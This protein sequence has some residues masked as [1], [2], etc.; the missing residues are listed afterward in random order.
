MATGTAFDLTV[1]G[2]F[3]PLERQ[4]QDVFRRTQA[5]FQKPIG[6]NFAK[7]LGTISGNADEFSKSMAAANARVVAFSASAGLVFGMA[8]AMNA[9]VTATIE[10]DK[11]FTDLN[12]LL[13]FSD[14]SL[15]D[16]GVDLVKVANDTG[17]SLLEIA[18]GA[19]ELARQGLGAEQTLIR[20]RDAGILARQ[21]GLTLDE[22]ITSLTATLNSFSR[23]A[24]ESTEVVN[25]FANVDAAFAVS[26]ADLA[27]A[28]KRVG[29][30]AATAGVEIDELIALV[31]SLQQTT[32]RGGSVIGNGLK[33]ILTR[34][35]R[36]QVLGQL[37]QAGVIIEDLEGKTLPTIQVLRNFAKT[38]QE[39]GDA[40]QSF[41]AEAVGSV[42]QINFLKALVSDLSKEYSIFD[43]A[44]NTSTTSTNEA[45]ERND[46]L[47]ESLAAS[48]NRVKNLATEIGSN[49][50]N[51]TVAPIL[52]DLIG[53][54]EISAD[55]FAPLEKEA[56]KSSRNVGDVLF[57]GLSKGIIEF[58]T[59]P[60]LVL[61]GAVI[62][63]LAIKF[64]QFTTEAVADFL[65]FNIA[66]NKNIEL[67]AKLNN[68]LQT[69]PQ[70]R[71]Q[72]LSTA[73]NQVEVEEQLLL[74][75]RQRLA[76]EEKINTFTRRAA[77]N[78][79]GL[80]QLDVTSTGALSLPKRRASGGLIPQAPQGLIPSNIDRGSALSEI[81]GAYEGG[82]KP[83]NLKK[84]FIKGVGDVVYNSAEQVLDFGFDQPAIVPPKNSKAGRN[85]QKNFLKVHGFDPF[86]DITPPRAS[87]RIAA[88]G[89]IPVSIKVPSAPKVRPDYEL[90]NLMVQEL[91][92][93]TSYSEEG[94]KN[95]SVKL[96]KGKKPKDK[97][98]I[99]FDDKNQ[100]ATLYN[101]FPEAA[102]ELEGLDE[103]VKNN[104]RKAQRSIVKRAAKTV[105]RNLTRMGYS[106]IETKEKGRDNISR[107][108]IID[109]SSNNTASDGFIPSKIAPA[110]FLPRVKQPSF[111]K[112]GRGSLSE[113]FDVGNGL[114]G[115]R[116]NPSSGIRNFAFELF[117]E[118]TGQ[119]RL[120]I[121]DFLKTRHGSEFTEANLFQQFIKG[122]TDL[123]AVSDLRNAAALENY[124]NPLVGSPIFNVAKPIRAATLPP[125]FTKEVFDKLGTDKVIFQKL[126]KG[127]IGSPQ[128]SDLVDSQSN[129]FLKQIKSGIIPFKSNKL[130]SISA[131]SDIK[132]ANIID[133][134][135]IDLLLANKGF[136]P[137]FNGRRY[138]PEDFR[139]MFANFKQ[140]NGSEY[141]FDK[142]IDK[143]HF[144]LLE[145]YFIPGLKEGRQLPQFT[146]FGAE[147][148]VFDVSENSVLK[149]PK[150]ERDIPFVERVQ[151]GNSANNIFKMAGAPFFSP[152]QRAIKLGNQKGVLQ[153][154]VEGPTLDNF[155]NEL[156]R[157]Q[158]ESPFEFD[159]AL[160]LFKPSI[161]EARK[162][163]KYPIYFDTGSLRNF[164]VPNNKVDGLKDLL[165]GAGENLKAKDIFELL[166][167]SKDRNLLATIDLS[168]GFVPNFGIP[169]S[170]AEAIQKLLATREKGSFFGV[171]FVKRTDGTLRKMNARLGVQK[172]KTG[173]GA[174]YNF[175]EKELIP[176]TDMQLLQKFAKSGS[177][178]E[179]AVQKAR[180]S[181][182]YEGI[183]KITI[184]GQE[185]DVFNRG[186]IPNS[187]KLAE[188]A[189]NKGFDNL[190]Y[191]SYFPLDDKKNPIREIRRPSKFPTFTNGIEPDLEGIAGFFAFD[192]NIA[193]RFQ[194]SNE[195][196]LSPFFAQS[197]K[198]Y[199]ID[200]KGDFAGNIQ[201]GDS[202]T[203]FRDIVRSKKYDSIIIK[204]TKDE[205]D[206]FVSL[207]SK[208]TKLALPET[209]D[210]LG[211]IVPL[212]KRFDSSIND[213]N[214]NRGLVPNFGLVREKLLETRLGK[215]TSRFLGGENTIFNL[216]NFNRASEGMIP[217]FVNNPFQDPFGISGRQFP[218]N[219]LGIKDIFKDPK[220]FFKQLPFRATAGIGGS[221]LG[222]GLRFSK[223]QKV[224][225]FGES[226]TNASRFILGRGGERTIKFTKEQ[227]NELFPKSGSKSDVYET[228]LS[229]ER[230]RLENIS[231]FEALKEDANLRSIGKTGFGHV[232]VSPE[233]P[234]FNA[235]GDFQGKTVNNKLIGRDVFDFDN[236]LTIGLRSELSQIFEKNLFSN[237]PIVNKLFKKF[238]NLGKAK[239]GPLGIN[240]IPYSN[241]GKGAKTQ[242]RISGRD[243]DFAD[244]GTPF[245]TKLQELNSGFVPNFNARRLGSG[246]FADFYDTGKF[247]K[248]G[249]PIGTK[250]FA[251]FVSDYNIKEEFTS[252]KTIDILNQRKELPSIF[253]APRVFGNQ[254]SAITNRAIDKEIISGKT[255]KD[256]F[257]EFR[258]FEIDDYFR[259]AEG[260]QRFTDKKFIQSPTSSFI[261]PDDTNLSNVILNDNFAEKIRGLVA[262]KNDFSKLLKSKDKED[263]FSLLDSFGRSGAKAS[264]ID[265]GEFIFTDKSRIPNFNAM[266]GYGA[267][268]IPN[269]APRFDFLRTKGQIPSGSSILKL[270]DDNPRIRDLSYLQGQKLPTQ[271]IKDFDIES[272]LGNISIKDS[273]I[274]GAKALRKPIP[275][276]LVDSKG[277][278]KFLPKKIRGR[279]D[280]IFSGLAFY[281]DRP[282]LI[283]LQGIAEDAFALQNSRNPFPKVFAEKLEDTILHEA[284]HFFD[285]NSPFGKGE[286]LS[287]LDKFREGLVKDIIRFGASI[288]EITGISVD[289]NAIKESFAELFRLGAQKKPLTVRTKGGINELDSA[290][291]F[292]DFFDAIFRGQKKQIPLKDLESFSSVSLF[293]GF[294]KGFVPNFANYS[295]GANALQEAVKREQD[296]GL[297][298]NQIKIGRDDRLKSIENPQG[299]GVFNTRDEPRG[300]RQGIERVAGMG[301]N[302]KRAGLLNTYATGFIPSFQDEEFEFEGAQ[303]RRVRNIR[304]RA[305]RAGADPNEAVQN[306]IRQ[307]LEKTKQLIRERNIKEGQ[308]GQVLQSQVEEFGLAKTSATKLSR[309]YLGTSNRLKQLNEIDIQKTLSE[310]DKTIERA[311]KARQKFETIAQ[312]PIKSEPSFTS[313]LITTGGKLPS[314]RPSPIPTLVD[315]SGRELEPSGAGLRTQ[316][317]IIEDDERRR[318]IQST[319][320][321]LFISE[322]A[323]ESLK[324]T[325]PGSDS[326]DKFINSFNKGIDARNK[327][328]TES[329]KEVF[330]TEGSIRKVITDDEGFR[331]PDENIRVRLSRQALG[332]PEAPELQKRL[333]EFEKIGPENVTSSQIR[334]VSRFREFDKGFT[335]FSRKIQSSLEKD[336]K[337]VE[338]SLF[339]FGKGF[340]QA[341]ERLKRQ[342]PEALSNALR[343]QRQNPKLLQGALVTSFAAPLVGG[344]LSEA[345]GD[346][347]TAQRGSQAA[348]GGLTNA[349]SFTAL[350]ASFGAS[351]IL[352]AGIGLGFLAIEIPKI[353]K[354]FSDTTPDLE[355]NLQKLRESVSETQNALQTLVTTQQ[356]LTDAY[357]GSIDVSA[358]TVQRLLRAQSDAI[359]SISPAERKQIRTSFSDSGSFSDAI[360]KINEQINREVKIEV[361]LGELTKLR[362]N[363]DLN[364]ADEILTEKGRS[365]AAILERAEG[366]FSFIR[367]QLGIETQGRTTQEIRE[368]I[369]EAVKRIPEGTPERIRAETNLRTGLF[370]NPLEN[371]EMG[372][373]GSALE[374][375]KNFKDSFKKSDI[376]SLIESELLKNQGSV[377]NLRNVSGSEG[378]TSLRKNLNQAFEGEAF[379]G[380]QQEAI[381]TFINSVNSVSEGNKDLEKITSNFKE[382]LSSFKDQPA[383]TAELLKEAIERFFGG[384]NITI[385]EEFLAEAKEAAQSLNNFEDVIQKTRVA[386]SSFQTQFNRFSQRLVSEQTSRTNF[387][388]NS[389]RATREI[390]APNVGPRTRARLEVN[391]NIQTILNQANLERLNQNSQF[392]QQIVSSV[393][394]AVD[395]FEQSALNLASGRRGGVRRDVVNERTQGFLNT[396]GLQDFL[397]FQ[398]PGD[399]EGSVTGL[400]TFLTNLNSISERLALENNE[401][402]V[403]DPFNKLQSELVNSLRL[404][405]IDRTGSNITLNEV[406]LEQV[407][408]N[409]ADE[410][411]TF[412]KALA[413]ITQN[414]LRD[415]AGGLKNIGESDR[416]E[417]DFL[418]AL[419]LVDTGQFSRR[420][421]LTAKGFTQLRSILSELGV[422][423]AFEN[424]IVE[425]GTADRDSFLRLVE[426]LVPGVRNTE[427]RFSDDGQRL[428]PEEIF[429]R[430]LN[431][432]AP[433][434]D[435]N[436][437]LA[438]E[439]ERI[440]G[441]LR[442][443]FETSVGGLN[444]SIDKL[445]TTISKLASDGVRISNTQEI[446][447]ILQG[448][449]SD[450]DLP[451]QLNGPG[452]L[453][454]E[455]PKVTALF[456]DIQKAIEGQE[457]TPEN[458]EKLKELIGGFKSSL[459][460]RGQTIF[461]IQKES[462]IP[463]EEIIQ[464]LKSLQDQSQE[465]YKLQLS[466]F[467][468]KE[469]KSIVYDTNDSPIPELLRRPTPK[470]VTVNPLPEIINEPNI[471]F[472]TIPFRTTTQGQPKN[473]DVGVPTFLQRPELDASGPKNENL[474]SRQ[475]NTTIDKLGTFLNSTNLQFAEKI[476]LIDDEVKKINNQ[477]TSNIN[478]RQALS[479]E[480]ETNLSSLLDKI[481]NLITEEALS[482]NRP[483]SRAAE[484]TNNEFRPA[485]L[486]LSNLGL[487]TEDLAE[488]IDG[489]R[490]DTAG[491][492]TDL[493]LGLKSSAQATKSLELAISK[494]QL[495]ADIRNNTIFSN[496]E[497]S[498]R[499]D[500]NVNEILEP[501]FSGLDAAKNSVKSFIDTFQFQT[502][503]LYKSLMEGS[504]DVGLTLKQ[505]FSA[506]FKSFIDGTNDAEDAFRQ[507]GL[508]I[509]DRILQ[510]T[511]DISTDL[512][513]G[514]IGTLLNGLSP[515]LGNLFGGNTTQ[516]ITRNNGGLV[517][518]FSSGGIVKGGRG[519]VDDVPALLSEGEYVIKAS[520]VK[521]LGIDNLESINELANE[522]ERPKV[523]DI[524][525]GPIRVGNDEIEPRLITNKGG[526]STVF[527][528]LTGNRA[529]FVLANQLDFKGATKQARA[530]FDIDRN[531]STIALTDDNN[532]Q[533]RLREER[534]QD[535]Q[536]FLGKLAAF[537]KETKAFDR[538]QEQRLI[539]AY[540]SAFVGSLG[541]GVSTVASANSSPTGGGATGSEGGSGFSFEGQ[542]VQSASFNDAAGVN[543]GG[544]TFSQRLSVPGGTSFTPFQ[545]S[546]QFQTNQNFGQ[547]FD[548]NFNRFNGNAASGGTIYQ[549]YAKGGII[550]PLKAKR[551]TYAGTQGTDNIPALLTA[552]E[553]VVRKPVVDTLG[554]DFFEKL[555]RGNLSTENIQKFQTGGLVT[556]GGVAI[557][558]IGPSIRTGNQENN[559]LNSIS[560]SINRFV[561][562]TSELKDLINQQVQPSNRTANSSPETG[563]TSSGERNITII[564]NVTVEKSG[565]VTAETEASSGGGDNGNKQNNQADEDTGR[566][567][568]DFVKQS[569]L[570]TIIEQKRPGGLLEDKRR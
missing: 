442:T 478:N 162:G 258:Y 186:L 26:S 229:K 221:L 542:N 179:E 551:N 166:K 344:I 335:E 286:E 256:I 534:F 331:L 195:S 184:E 407:L 497:T 496:E 306:E 56:E 376:F 394:Q 18:S 196:L 260:F 548:P 405:A 29:S 1:G 249:L 361:S 287:S 117:K 368:A 502:K 127:N 252:A 526:K 395:K 92:Q 235:V 79:T 404:E 73:A 383:V 541:A 359:A 155:R 552:G 87:T 423:N 332:V 313:P 280:L 190:V 6:G 334:D 228:R 263:L 91:G 118:A 234:L 182:P 38:F 523:G 465:I 82:Y 431:Q 248:E 153:R 415:F 189:K 438:K 390:I 503:D 7:P 336:I 487:K 93:P 517:Q 241:F 88:E 532:P 428:S 346:E 302:P 188:L 355:R 242:F 159:K 471:P 167:N 230:E 95:L 435:P 391:D 493:I 154:K 492:Q 444:G 266:R 525:G 452:A 425:A 199:I 77:R 416:Q 66:V 74:L 185:Y 76:A 207:N 115:K 562:V 510:I 481:D 514:G 312:L 206:L 424:E 320:P 536:N 265:T 67:Q 239:F 554:K 365:I 450:V 116:F 472:D 59:G 403:S 192:K 31:T 85:F 387:D 141:G 72:A 528:T 219:I 531:L 20:L 547:V 151:R 508:N 522:P 411:L 289:G 370:T 243:L 470:E 125:N 316:R 28:I 61:L 168:Q 300:L 494:A 350:S 550:D 78:F 418:N 527:G 351:P 218:S 145:K 310:A 209:R 530:A 461:D 345:I 375:S 426:N 513:F 60:G 491:L 317:Q 284:G 114:V 264:L 518:R 384:E 278:G 436:L 500:N 464:S 226:I 64:A 570:Q 5:L 130:D 259:F 512:L 132:P 327:Q 89:S 21:G 63:K 369:T 433:P 380:N 223:N 10:V 213:F 466:G 393:V 486:G 161:R 398:R 232:R 308:V 402:E 244:Y 386:L 417:E 97:N 23:Q 495:E 321:P 356:Q 137:N 177:S 257:E 498:R 314:G 474:I 270:L 40:Q 566:K 129:L 279:K 441:D 338:N 204:N 434:E 231:G 143:G 271:S 121:E 214:F 43:S 349:A 62:G 385:L 123:N 262:N 176:V 420:D 34:I 12:V 303:T 430:Q 246:T 65:N 255:I 422:D 122:A 342:S 372:L 330:A 46:R 447:N 520:T 401:A 396:A 103:A 360:N 561:Q 164:I 400:N 250:K 311:F 30:T 543:Y 200:A 295:G 75:V 568:A 563:N 553:Y 294:N 37:Q 53:K 112:I 506:G 446:N 98:L 138:T 45:I 202:G 490:K 479:K 397:D 373:I 509:A 126:L 52:N 215:T 22:S 560:E 8:K 44:L 480:A 217:N 165:S 569:A 272:I 484:F 505:E 201:F 57:G 288:N 301:L 364:N 309:T 135:I 315:P 499:F 305:T 366:S 557:N 33:T 238:P 457:D 99:K 187:N 537:E 136:I 194:Y 212:S 468:Q 298:I 134:T 469:A 205:K 432:A 51:V 50:G 343:V 540:S 337:V 224:R 247:S 191:K 324:Q 328:F 515:T 36:P 267:K 104:D 15:K 304:R 181:I 49:I 183:K 443:A 47:N 274:S 325:A 178:S 94:A 322:S 55:F 128:F 120:K 290:G 3:R 275:L 419:S 109:T 211:N 458:R 11:A 19:T 70:L 456:S 236:S 180:R 100:T 371:L 412:K 133:D 276:E 367:A 281:D 163:Q 339:R 329:V 558:D 203:E 363:A 193:K 546:S 399:F 476:K 292:D 348:V 462:G 170:R 148:N 210:E 504:R 323:R 54:F 460:T 268:K 374:F 409:V 261:F 297:S 68:I 174:P 357:T 381:D 299:L 81:A 414:E 253:T 107:D 119:P 377:E 269:F 160:D 173:E 139:T 285:I 382:F 225:G 353:I 106:G 533:N 48:I 131:I 150:E 240:T 156:S 507:F 556:N 83:G 483:S 362:E 451:E 16:F 222:R 105:K 406:Q 453:F 519:G 392:Q 354:G 539:G 388:I 216:R 273:I 13:N 455:K 124:T 17:Q 437:V 149:L 341:S 319:R 71:Q 439:N 172:G 427:E 39:V 113:V 14:A 140:R 448:I 549:F 96:N 296:A 233:A 86:G 254:K 555:N 4:A 111:N 521:K 25:K 41:L 146:S 24:L 101:M 524:V 378:I 529:Q 326:L 333:Q 413:D 429:R 389:N 545:S 488:V 2:D 482:R 463:E 421:D 58:A 475:T 283:N 147:A 69:D 459:T 237:S 208:Q 379:L 307:E 171:E 80:G 144:E 102:E 9:L 501:D 291:S 544:S 347:T 108:L 565:N 511:S 158:F 340:K 516:P 27:E 449:I 152:R 197:K 175:S 293:A 445:D 485:L 352:A 169:I 35:E 559:N 32:A 198:P 477:S 84:T 564:T 42:F 277:L 467:T 473:F 142:A 110:G 251:E 227:A 408:S 410:A 282:P 90:T 567:L 245:L 535:F 318:A 454:N 440:F 157:K 489:F 538:A 358:Q 220:K